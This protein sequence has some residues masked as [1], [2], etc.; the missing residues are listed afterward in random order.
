MLQV[1]T[2][3]ILMGCNGRILSFTG[4]FSCGRRDEGTMSK[5]TN[6]GLRQRE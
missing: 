6:G 4:T 2:F 3:S 1:L 5:R